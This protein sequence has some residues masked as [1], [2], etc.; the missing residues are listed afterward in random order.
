MDQTGWSWCSKCQ[1]LFYSANSGSVCPA[2]DAHDPSGSGEY[3]L[4]LNA[5][6]AAHPHGQPDWSWCGKCQGL[7]YGPGFASSRCP[8]GDAHDGSGSGNYTLDFVG[9][10][11]PAEQQRGWS[12]CHVCQGLF[13]GTGSAG[14]CP[15]G[16][17]H[18]S[19]G[20]GAYV[21]TL[22]PAT[23]P[24]ML[25]TL[26]PLL[27]MAPTVLSTAVRN[28]PVFTP[29]QGTAISADASATITDS[30]GAKWCALATWVD[31]AAKAD[32]AVWQCRSSQLTITFAAVVDA[33]V[34]PFSAG[35]PTASLALPGGATLPLDPVLDSAQL[36]LV[37]TFGT[38]EPGR[39]AYDAA[40]GVLSDPGG[41]RLTLAN[42][43]DLVVQTPAPPAPDPQPEPDPGPVE[44][45]PRKPIF[46]HPGIPVFKQ[47]S[48]AQKPDLVML[49]QSMTPALA[50]RI[51]VSDLVL[52][53]P[54][55]NRL[56]VPPDPGP[57]G[58]TSTTA[59]V[60]QNNTV[61]LAWKAQSDADAF[62]DIPHQAAGGW[63]QVTPAG[64]SQSLHC[65]PGSRP[66]L[67][68]YLP[69]EFRLAF[70]A[71]TADDVPATPFR[72]TLS[73]ADDGTTKVTVTMTAMPYLADD[74]RAQLR[75]YLL[76]H[77]LNGTQPYVELAAASGLTA[78]FQADFLSAGE[79]VAMSSIRYTLDGAASSDL[80]Q[81][82]FTMDELDYRFLVPMLERGI[83]GS[84]VLAD[85]HISVAVP[86]NLHLERVITNALSVTIAPVPDPPPDPFTGAVTVANRLAYPVQ[87]SRLDVDLVF[88]GSSSDVIFDAEELVAISNPLEIDASKSS[89]PEPYAPTLA[90]WTRVAVVPGV[91][92]VLGPA[93]A[94]WVAMVNRD[95]SLQPSKITVALSPSIPAVHAADIRSITVSVYAAG[96]TS[97]H[98]P[99]LDCAPGQNT[100]LELDL[101]LPEIA[102]GVDPRTGFVLEFTS[103]FAD[104]NLSLPQRIALDL[105]Q[106]TIDLVVLWEPPGA[107]YFVDGDTTI[108]PVTREVAQQVIETL[109]SSGKTWRVR[110]VAPA[111]TT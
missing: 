54:D 31:F 107:A 59:T 39:A 37:A 105:T 96:A 26:A 82:S 66:E 58:A 5:D 62:P 63:M 46:V 71:A 36:R 4:D 9:D 84:V 75:E 17:Q 92:S 94:D 108:G 68:Y 106:H 16:G 34:L 104:D 67:F 13:F 85:E 93:P 110:A 20:S 11:T 2:G 65:L 56:F 44:P 48:F 90:S 27:F 101:T 14:V 89:D 77:V 30:T 109:R 25:T 99:P 21:V 80:L 40:I 8:A 55:W 45:F 73:R 7:G 10:D 95:P 24:V 52:D 74:D 1:G 69:T 38:D 47:P 12:W 111:P 32:A 64:S 22:R 91:A 81:I 103:R 60:A 42:S 87:L 83:T 15:A 97:P 19:S 70:H 88:A 53:R 18:D 6:A 72:V 79:P 41:A 28:Q 78:T 76:Q 61:S 49:R 86:V 23:H 43:H 33:Q 50:A 102:A 51:N 98:Q 29:D 100:T 57:Q 35:S 3:V